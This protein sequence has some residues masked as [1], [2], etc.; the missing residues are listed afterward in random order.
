MSTFYVLPPR[1]VLGERFAGFLQLVFPGLRWEA[2]TRA[3]LADVLGRTAARADVFVV[4]R[5][6][7]PPDE[8]VAR[9]LVD[10]FGAEPGDEV[11][12]VRPAGPCR[13]ASLPQAGSLAGAE[14]AAARW[15]VAPETPCLPAGPPPQ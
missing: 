13:P 5:D 7:L 9:A 11:I 10:A 4:Y 14:L 2:A 15:H 12:E 6:D 8:P 1:P 3:D